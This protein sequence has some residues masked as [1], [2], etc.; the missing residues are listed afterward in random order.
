[1]MPEPIATPAG[2]PV[3]NSGQGF[4]QLPPPTFVPATPTFEPPGLSIRATFLASDG[5]RPQ[6]IIL[7]W[8]HDPGQA[9]L[10]FALDKIAELA[11]PSEVQVSY[12]IGAVTGDGRPIPPEDIETERGWAREPT[13]ETQQ[14]PR[15][16]C[17]ATGLGHDDDGHR[18]TLYLGHDP[19]E[20]GGRVHRC[21]CGGLFGLPVGM[22]DDVPGRR[23]QDRRRDREER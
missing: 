9:V 10:A 7:E 14:F 12:E 20:P 8:K 2:D 13:A 21:R 23:E 6:E 5:S 4:T 1:M 19:V 3:Y 17:G 15:P 11:R 22:P 16:F 18:C